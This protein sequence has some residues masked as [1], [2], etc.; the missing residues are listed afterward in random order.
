MVTSPPSGSDK[1]R[2]C[3]RTE[4]KPGQ[5]TTRQEAEI[6]PEHLNLEMEATDWTLRGNAHLRRRSNSKHTDW[7]NN[8]PVFV[9]LFEANL[10]VDTQTVI[11][12]VIC[13]V[14]MLLYHTIYL[15]SAVIHRLVPTYSICTF[16]WKLCACAWTWNT[17]VVVSSHHNLRRVF[18]YTKKRPLKEYSWFKISSIDSIFGS[19][20]VSTVSHFGLTHSNALKME[21]YGARQFT[22][23]KVQLVFVSLKHK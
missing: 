2:Q 23:K 5:T 17:D 20:P 12:H 10:S 7:H 1:E 18:G 19:V 4:N 21:V 8:V 14:Y 6:E 15:W 16:V 22:G 11:T 13:H 9:C 3:R